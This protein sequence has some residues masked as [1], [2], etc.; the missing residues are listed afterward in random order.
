LQV[1]EGTEVE[2]KSGSENRFVIELVE[3]PAMEEEP[4]E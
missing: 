4:V 1:K 2:V 3:G